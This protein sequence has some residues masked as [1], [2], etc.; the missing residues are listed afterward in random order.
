[1]FWGNID[2]R[3]D[4]HNDTDGHNDPLIFFINGLKKAG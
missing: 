4:G 1:M 2:Y 3:Q